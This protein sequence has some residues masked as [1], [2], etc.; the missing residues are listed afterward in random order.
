M[1]DCLQ[2]LSG[3]FPF[4]RLRFEIA[5]VDLL[6]KTCNRLIAADRRMFRCKVLEMLE[7]VAEP[8]LKQMWMFGGEH[9]IHF[10]V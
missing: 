4:H 8:R 3:Y 1:R 7:H 5:R 2:K 6:Q 10:T 9:M